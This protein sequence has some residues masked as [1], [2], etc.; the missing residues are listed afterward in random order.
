MIKQVFINLPVKDLNKSV[1]F[2]TKLG[3]KFDERF[4]NE[5]A[6]CM[7]VSETIYVMLL[8]ESFFNGFTKNQIAD[9]SKQ[10]EVIVAFSV[11]SQNEVDEMVSKGLAAGGTK[12]Y[13]MDMEG[14][15]SVAFSDPDGHIWEILWMDITKIP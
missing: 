2:F 13:D 10:S 9:T 4:T 8:T 11:D 12:K 7:I 1:E 3:F 14:M 15:H 6:T 5:K